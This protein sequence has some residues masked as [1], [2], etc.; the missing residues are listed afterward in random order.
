MGLGPPSVFGLPLKSISKD[1]I[2]TVP[3]LVLSMHTESAHIAAGRIQKPISMSRAQYGTVN[4]YD[5]VK[6]FKLVY[7]Y[8]RT[9]LLTPSVIR[10]INLDFTKTHDRHHAVLRTSGSGYCKY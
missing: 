3:L 10:L 1:P 6:R 2:S 9:I 5:N 4:L 8:Y 7:L